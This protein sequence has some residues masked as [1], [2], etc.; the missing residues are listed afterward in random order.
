M[1]APTHASSG[2][3][4][5]QQMLHTRRLR[6]VVAGSLLVG[7]LTSPLTLRGQP[8]TLNLSRDL[9]T[10]GIAAKN[11]VPN[12]PALNAAALFQAGVEY[13][14]A[15][16]IS[17]VTAD[18]GSYYF[19]ATPP[20][21]PDRYTNL[22]YLSN[23]TIDLAGSTVYLGQRFL[24][25]FSLNVSQNVTLTNFTIERLNAPYTHVQITAVDAVNRRITYSPLPGFADPA[26]LNG[27]TQPYG[28]VE[29]WAVVFRNGKILP[30]T[31]RMEV[32]LPIVSGS[33]TLVSQGQPWL[34][35]ATLSTLQPGDTLV[36][37][38]RGG[39]PPINV[40]WSTSMVLSN[41]TVYGA[42]F[43][44]LNLE[45]TSESIVENVQVVPKPGSGLVGSNTGAIH[46]MWPGP[47]NIVRNNRLMRTMDD[48]IAIEDKYAA[49]IL[50]QTG[51]RSLRV[52][53]NW[54]LRLPN[55]TAFNFLDPETPRVTAGALLV[56]QNP[57]YS[58][59][60]GF[61]S[62]TE[63]TFDRALPSPLPGSYL[64]HGTPTRRG[65]GTIVEDNTVEEVIFGQ[66]IWIGSVQAVTVR[67]NFVRET[68]NYA[69]GVWQHSVMQESSSG[70]AAE[71]I[72]IDS[73]VVQSGIGP[74]AQGVGTQHAMGAIGV[75]Y[76][77]HD[78]SLARTPQTKNVNIVS[79]YVADS[80]RT[81]IWVGSLQGGVLTH[82]RI[83]RW[84]RHPELPI[85]GTLPADSAIA[86]EDFSK[87]IAIRFS[88]NVADADNQSE[89]ESP[90][91][92]AVNL[93][94]SAG[95]LTKVAS[96]GTIAVH[97][98]VPGFFQWKARSDA[99]W[100][101]V[102]SQTG[103]GEGTITYSTTANDTGVERIGSITVAGVV[104]RVTQGTG[105]TIPPTMAI[106][107]TWLRLNAVTNGQTFVWQTA[108]QTIQLT[109]SG[110]GT[111]TWTATSNQPWLVVTPAS[112]TGSAPLTVSLK[113][114]AGLEGALNGSI[115]MTFSGAGTSSA[116][117][118]VYA[119][120][121]RASVGPFGWVD[122]PAENSTG[123]TG[124][125]PF[126]GWALD[127]ID[128]TDIF[129]CRAVVAGEIAP[130]DGH[131]NGA[132]QIYVGS[133]IFLDGARPDVF[134][135][136][137]GLPLASRA[138]WGFMVLTNML[139]NQGNGSYAFYIYA[140]DRD[141]HMV[142]LGTR[143]MTCDNAHATRP[144]GAIDTPAQGG[145]AS[146]S[147]F[148]N[149]GWALTQGGKFIPADGS[150][151][152]VLIDGA[153]RGTVDYNHSRPDIA[154][155]FPGLANTNGAIGFRI[156]DT[157]AMNNGIHTISWTVTDSAG[158]TEGI[159]SRFF[160]VTNGLSALTAESHAERRAATTVQAITALPL[161]RDPVIGRRG[162]DLSAPWRAYSVGGAGRA[163]LRGEE[164]DRFELSLGD[165]VPSRYR[166][167]LHMGDTLR[168]LP[169]GSTL[170]PETGTFTWA[171][172][173][174]FVGTYD[175]V[176][177][178]T[179][180]G[181][182]TRRE[183]RVILAPKGSVHVGVQV[184]IDTPRTNTAVEQPFALG[185][186]AADLDAALGTGIDSLHVWAYPVA[187]GP[188]IFLGTPAL[189]GSRLDVAA[190]H[191]DR[192]ADSGFGFTVQ[193][194]AAGDYDLAVFP[195]SN[196]T[197]AFGPP[198]LVRVKAR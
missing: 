82:N 140:R 62:E 154:S 158:Q 89:L 121:S 184:E 171:P 177:I 100:L 72:T 11:M 33:V 34:E 144:F 112:G 31:S 53:R 122:T 30:G 149:F 195:W 80:G 151:I 106:D 162:W 22:Y 147:Q 26:S 92:G 74:A 153:D 99:A 188:P 37:T 155:L 40:L 12:D 145:T 116:V 54:W 88:S 6:L 190:G 52:R 169:I 175:L 118:A 84:N 25:G 160:T 38:L 79:N 182:D 73:N 67:R 35:P 130:V 36:V 98:N 179:T 10:L 63:L 163:V 186:W 49:A 21:L 29:Y 170:D 111:V 44:A 157:T 132:A 124:A 71:D 75:N 191:G 28:P 8:T 9:V 57:A 93:Q 152:H 56:S 3:S 113:P 161:D 187:G 138:G 43:E 172:G 117:A 17:R 85:G 125:V 166:G 192:F 173:V 19:L 76:M 39:G 129:I 141:G 90:L 32:A 159:G 64:V 24:I 135:S 108:P 27:L 178:R 120:V 114:I 104:F 42:N 78:F 137:S 51:P 167:Y 194:L 77:S 198:K 165:S 86:L 91:E 146:G 136:F 70:Q 16:H 127:D 20:S 96:S 193:G 94:P 105:S 148:V 41:I 101:T 69:I 46:L 139:P 48:A 164:V 115:T 87:P 2:P 128:V 102:V 7:A 58:D 168:P 156:L 110:T 197:N 196:V 143:N 119:T 109:Q 65:S 107:R 189:G 123:V 66:G 95:F 97:S 5:N 180:A 134:A 1:M 55:N 142:L 45:Q 150:T 18:R 126:T 185:G 23:M 47:N 174:G 14:N 59:F 133:A 181:H 176:F 4:I 60:P 81:G 131:C 61:D 50:S 103:V 83:V 13:A 68:S 183:V 15:H